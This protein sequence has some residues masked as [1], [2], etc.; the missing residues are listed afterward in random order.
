MADGHPLKI[1]FVQETVSYGNGTI[2][3]PLSQFSL[4]ATNY[5]V[6]YGNDWGYVAG[7]IKR[8]CGHYNFQVR[9]KVTQQFWDLHVPYWKQNG[10]PCFGV[11][12]TPSGWCWSGMCGPDIPTIRNSIFGALAAVGVISQVAD[13]VSKYTAPIINYAAVVG[14]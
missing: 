6:I 14:L 9:N 10:K 1:E 2:S 11:Y 12:V 5:M 13:Y 7:C 3:A 8:N 4:P